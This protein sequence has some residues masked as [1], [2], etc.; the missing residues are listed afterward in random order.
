MSA[1]ANSNDVSGGVPPSAQVLQLATAHFVARCLQVVATAGIADSVSDVPRPAK[2]IAAQVDVNADALHR[3]LRLLATQGIFR[4]EGNGWV[5]TPAS[6]LLRTDNPQ[7]MR[8][9]AAMMGDPVNL[10]SLEVLEYTL[11]TG[12]AGA[13]KVFPGGA[14]GYYSQ[15]PQ[16]AR[17]FD[18][19]MTSKSQG[20]IPLLVGALD[21]ANCKTIADIAGGRGHFLQAIVDA[22]PNL[23]GILFDQPD[24]VANGQNHPR[25][26]KVGGD[27]FKGELPKADLY[28]MVHI[29]HDWAD[30]ECLAILRNLRAAAPKGARLVVFELALPEG[31][32][33]HPA[34]LLDIIMLSITGGRER[35]AK[36]YAKLFASAGWA[37][38]GVTLTPGPMALHKARAA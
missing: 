5:H 30:E 15:H 22:H 12:D 25:I 36:E 6:A 38:D 31:P 26:S 21:V 16:M 13:H 29:L 18:A 14:W 17:Q 24:V 23:K 37:D 19:A 4:F 9:F 1:F 27:F 34:K 7:S 10:Q 2:D 3:M 11:K 32:E 33:P 28:L 20:D 35:T 8:A